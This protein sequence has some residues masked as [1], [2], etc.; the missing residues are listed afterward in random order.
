M[1]AQ[2]KPAKEQLTGLIGGLL[3]S[4]KKQGHG[5]GPHQGYSGYGGPP[6]GQGSYGGYRPPGQY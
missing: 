3:G 2:L 1:A 6:P 5:G 4:K